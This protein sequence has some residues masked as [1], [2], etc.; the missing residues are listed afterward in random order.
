MKNIKLKAELLEA[1]EDMDDFARM[2]NIEPIGAYNTLKDGIEYLFKHQCPN[3]GPVINWLKNGCDV[4]EAIKE[5]E[6]YQKVYHG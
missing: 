1:L 5:L 2:A 3:L 6:I 4:Q